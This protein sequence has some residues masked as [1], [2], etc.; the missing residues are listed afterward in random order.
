MSLKII[1]T[2]LSE[3]EI[4]KDVRKKLSFDKPPFSTIDNDLILL[5]FIP[6][7]QANSYVSKQTRDRL[8]KKFRICDHQSLEFYGDS[9]LYAVIA[10]ILY[11]LFE[12]NNSPAF[13]TQ[14]KQ[15]FTNNRF[16]TDI[17]L[18]KEVCSNIRSINYTIHD[19]KTGF[20]N[21]CADS[22][23]AVI[24]IMY[25]HLRD[26]NVDPIKIIKE[27]ILHNTNIP[28]HLNKYLNQ[29]GINN[30]F[31][32]TQIDKN[33]LISKLNNKTDQLIENLEA[34]DPEDDLYQNLLE[35]IELQ[36]TKTLDDFA[37][38]TIIVSQDDKLQTI[39]RKLGWKYHIGFNSELNLFEIVGYPNN[40][41][42]I[43]GV[44]E[45]VEETLNDA[46]EYLIL[47]GHIVL[48]KDTKGVFVH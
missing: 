16:L 45:T 26:N 34:M 48:M 5:A 22:F 32:F 36:H 27:W 10:D 11:S 2:N 24:G 21:R 1:T 23:E 46:L 37:S 33:E 15:Y 25:I 18:E 19:T 40:T 14:I 43:I 35:A 13:L 39:Y 38:R 29:M 7:C 42:K 4:I 6:F 47:T 9:I 41:P 30:N 44:G 8:M 3:D 31:V 17:M 12:L 20:H 28:F